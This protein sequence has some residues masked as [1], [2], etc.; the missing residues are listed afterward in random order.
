MLNIFI[1]EDN[2]QQQFRLE[3]IVSGILADKGIKA[4]HL[5]IFE[6]PSQLLD[7]ISEKGSHQLFLLD[8]E[9]KDEVRKGLDLAKEIRALDSLAHIVFVTTH[10]EFLT[11][12]YRYKVSALD[13]IDKGQN[14]AELTK[15]LDDVMA[16]VLEQAAGTSHEDLFLFKTAY[17]H[18]QVPFHEIYYFET[19]EKS[20]K[21]NLRTRTER[22]EFYGK[23]SE[24]LPLDKRLYQSH[25]SYV[26]NPENIIELNY[27]DNMAIFPEEETCLVSRLKMKGLKQRILE[28]N[29]KRNKG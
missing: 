27:K 5:N 19:S 13:F 9:I 26:V 23:L 4:R 11:L 8:I 2:L 20:H 7:S 29:N 12:T 3:K 10:S 18:V 22:L 17:A 15:C 24:I 28:N 14:D 6:K 1:L 16:Y 25:R 21:I